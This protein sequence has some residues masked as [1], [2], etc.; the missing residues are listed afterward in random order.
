MAKTRKP[1][2]F[3]E[4]PSWAI[5]S[6]KR[7][8]YTIAAAFELAGLMRKDIRLTAEAQRKVFGAVLFG[9]C[10]IYVSNH[11]INASRSACFGTDFS[12]IAVN[13][14]EVEKKVATGEPFII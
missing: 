1:M 8:R 3:E 10:R 14:E 13:W 4:I 11:G 12:S 9:K 7:D 5:D 6:T 2:K